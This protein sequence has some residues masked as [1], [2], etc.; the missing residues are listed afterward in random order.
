MRLPVTLVVISVTM[1][2]CGPNASDFVGHYPV[3]AEESIEDCSGPSS[4]PTALRDIT[5][6]VISERTDDYIYVEMGPCG[7][8]AAVTDKNRFETEEATCNVEYEPPEITITFS[9]VGILEN[10]VL[11]LTLTGKYETTSLGYNV[12]CASYT[13]RATGQ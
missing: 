5:E 7:F 6:V 1:A 8:V 11:D 12:E 3:T 9:A 10:W 13:L 4:P 2:G